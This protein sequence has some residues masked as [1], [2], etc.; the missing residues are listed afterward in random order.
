MNYK[1][2]SNTRNYLPWVVLFLL[3]FFLSISYSIEQVVIESA[4][5]LT[6]KI[7]FPNGLN[8]FFYYAN[9]S[10][11]FTTQLTQIFLNLNFEEI[12]ISRIILF[13]STFFYSTGVYLISKNISS[14]RLLAIFIV[15][16]VMIFRKNFGNIDYP[17]LMF[18]EHTNGMISLSVASMIFGLICNK[19]FFLSTFFIGIL[20]SIHL[21]VGLWILFLFLISYLYYNFNEK[22][23]LPKKSFIFGFSLGLF[24]SLIS[25]YYFQNNQIKIPYEL[26]SNSYD[27]YMK[28]WDAHRNSYGSLAFL[29]YSYVFKSFILF[30]ILLVYSKFLSNKE[31]YH[32]KFFSIFLI[33]NIFISFVLY[34]TYKKAPFLYPD[35]LIRTIPTRFFLMH[36]VIG[37]PIIISS[38]YLLFI[39]L[40][41]KF[42]IYPKTIL[43]VFASLILFYSASHY[44]NINSLSQNFL[45]NLNEQNKLNKNSFWK[46]VKK[47]KTTGYIV[48]S[49]LAC[50]STITKANKPVI[51]CPHPIDYIPYLPKLSGKIELVMREIYEYSFSSPPPKTNEILDGL[52]DNAIKKIFEKKSS[53]DWIKIKNN[54]IVEGVIA[55]S[56]WSLNLEPLIIKENY[57]FYKIP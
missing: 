29:N 14:S 28:N 32:L 47:L 35:I 10:W 51:I 49:E 34:V 27:N 41:Q 9:N 24:I 21:T 37:Y 36:S 38:F 3:S 22:I 43:T 18:S 2:K 19:N 33:L 48:T 12:S 45:F 17:T 53:Q 40:T 20:I 31:N 55:P 16:F 15:F 13:I 23:K 52:R 50:S 8:I 56:N 1:T 57:T 11:S 6:D 5:S 25:F 4:I 44:K 46:E 30:L 7:S 54:F 39:N 26:M 42:N